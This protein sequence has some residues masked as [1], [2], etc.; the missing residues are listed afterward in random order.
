MKEMGSTLPFSEQCI[1]ITE[2]VKPNEPFYINGIIQKTFIEVNEKG[3]EAA[4][5]IVLFDDDMVCSLY[6]AP[7]PR[8]VAD[9]PFLFIVREEV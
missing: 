9:Y 1:E 2:I 8:F 3:T 4:V 6:E 5:I 7:H